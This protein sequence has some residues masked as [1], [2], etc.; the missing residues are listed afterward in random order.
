MGQVF[1]DCTAHVPSRALHSHLHWVCVKGSPWLFLGPP[2]QSPHCLSS[3][4][5]L[6]PQR[7]LQ[8]WG[9]SEETGSPRPKTGRLD[10]ALFLCSWALVTRLGCCPQAIEAA[11]RSYQASHWADEGSTFAWDP[12]QVCGSQPLLPGAHPSA[13]LG[14]LR[15][16]ALPEVC[17]GHPMLCQA[18]ATTLFSWTLTASPDLG[19]LLISL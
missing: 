4:E 1:S 19:F 3:L 12:S 2:A 5:C 17:S 15:M 14:Q 16:H 10:R 7:L 13:G 8:V 11:L 6:S 9:R 18:S